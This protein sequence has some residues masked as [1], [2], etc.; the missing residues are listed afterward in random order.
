MEAPRWKH[1]LAVASFVAILAG[2][3]VRLLIPDFFSDLPPAAPFGVASFAVYSA[4]FLPFLWWRT[5]I[6]YV[7][8]V[9]LGVIGLVQVLLIGAM[10]ASAVETYIIIIP[11]VVFALLLIGASVLAWREG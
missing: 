8:G 5:T 2:F 3:V 6:G 9:V 7:G 10:V 1:Q 11:Q 4:F